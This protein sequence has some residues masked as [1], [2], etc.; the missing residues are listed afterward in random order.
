MKEILSASTSKHQLKFELLK[1][2][3]ENPTKYY[4]YTATFGIV[5]I[6]EHDSRPKSGYGEQCYKAYG[7]FFKNGK[8]IKPDSAWMKQ[9]NFI[10]YSR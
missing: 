6:I 10:P 3:K 4:T 5:Y 9:Y 2:S 7:G 8:I 1:L